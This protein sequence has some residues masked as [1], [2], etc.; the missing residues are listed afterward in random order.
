MGRFSKWEQHT[1]YGPLKL[2]EIV[3]LHQ[4]A[5]QP[6]GQIVGR[7][8]APMRVR[9]S[10]NR[11]VSCGV[12]VRNSTPNCSF[13]D[14][15]TGAPATSM[16]IW[17]ADGKISTQRESPV[18]TG[19]GLRMAHPSRD[20][21]IA[22]PLHSSGPLAENEQGNSTG[23]RR[24]FRCSWRVSEGMRTTVLDMRFT[25]KIVRS[26]RRRRKRLLSTGRAEEAIMIW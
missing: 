12:S 2:F 10:C 17:F 6:R 9:K 1:Q 23:I 13:A 26:E 19:V 21:L 25:L 5:A 7:L 18:R 24:N 15:R 11:V 22:V 8:H 14:H 16:G 20:R 3:R 4:E